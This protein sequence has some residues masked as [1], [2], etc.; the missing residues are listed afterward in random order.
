MNSEPCDEYN[1]FSSIIFG[2]SFHNLHNLRMC[3][4][5][6]FTQ[7]FDK[8]MNSVHSDVVVTWQYLLCDFFEKKKRWLF[9]K[10]LLEKEK[11][12]IIH[13]LAISNIGVINCKFLKNVGQTNPHNY[14]FLIDLCL[15]TSFKDI[16]AQLCSSDI[17]GD[18][19]YQ[20]LWNLKLVKFFK[21]K[22]HLIEVSKLHP[23]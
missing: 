16:F 22:W 9:I 7:K 14:I 12:K 1:S 15:I 2:H 17:F 10:T 23:C 20:H 8:G 6:Y 4:S 21:E 19:L 11:Y 5:Q 3:L 18:G 13:S